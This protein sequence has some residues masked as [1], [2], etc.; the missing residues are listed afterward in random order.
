MKLFSKTAFVLGMLLVGYLPASNA[1]WEAINDN[2]KIGQGKRTYNK[3]EKTLG[4]VVKIKNESNNQYIEPLRLVISQSSHN[5]INQDGITES[6]L[7]Y[8]LLEG[9]ILPRKKLHT[10][11]E[12]SYTPSKLFFDGYLEQY[13]EDPEP[14]DITPP[15]ITLVGDAEFAHEQGTLFVDP[16]ATAIDDKDGS[17][18]VV[19]DG[20]VEEVAGSYTLVY[21]ASDVAGNSASVSRLV[22]VADTLSPVITLL[23]DREITLAYEQSYVELGATALDLV[24]GDV[25]VDISGEVLAEPGEYTITYTA[26]DLAGNSA[27]E[28]RLVTVLEAPVF[29]L[30]VLRGGEVGQEWDRK[31][32]AFDAA[33]GYAECNEDGGA[34]CPS[35]SWEWV[36]DT[37]RGNVLQISHADNNQLAGFFIGSSDAVDLSA[38]ETG[39]LKFDVQVVSGDSNITFKLDCFYPC[40]SGDY[41]IGEKGKDGW[42]T[43][44]IDV[45][46]L[47]NRGLNLQQVN[48]GIVIWASQFTNTVFKLD[49]IHFIG[50]SDVPPP[51]PP[52][53]FEYQISNY[54]LGTISNA[55]NPNSYRCVVDYGNW[56]YN[57]GVV[58]PAIDACDALTGI[59]TGTPKKRYPQVIGDAA[60]KPTP[61]HKWWGSVS[62]LGEMTI[63]DPNDGA[64]ITPDPIT[65]RITDRGFR[66]MGIPAGL[67]T[68]GNSFGY[69]IPDPFSEVFDGLAI[70]NSIHSDLNAYVSDSSDASVTIQWLNSDELVVMQATF[71]HGSSYVYLKAFDGDFVIKSLRADGGEKGVYFQKDNHLGIW[72]NVAGNHNNFLISGEGT[73]VFENI[74]SNSIGVINE[75][76][77]ITV[78]WLPV[79]NATP[80]EAQI[81]AF[82]TLAR[83]VVNRVEIDYAVDRRDNSVTVTHRYFDANSQ[84]ISTLV[85]LQ[86]LHWKNANLATQ[87]PVRSA[88]GITKYAQVSEFSYKLPYVGVLPSLPT[89]SDSL[90]EQT[91]VTLLDEFFTIE[92]AMWNT[93]TDAYW[94][95]KNY[96]KVAELIALADQ[97]GLQL[98][99]NEMRNWLKAEL[100]DWFTAE[101]NDALDEVKYFVYDNDWNTLLALE[102]SFSSHQQ[103]N[104]H[105]FHYG[106]FIRAAAEICRV[107]K[108]WC[109][110][111]QFGPIIEL[112]IRDFAAGK[113]DE[114]FPYVRNFDPANGFSWAS[115]SVN[116]V[117]GNNNESTSEAANA[118]G[119]IVLY[120]LITQNEELVERGMYLHASTSAAY[121]EYW[122]NID[123][124]AQMNDEANNFPNDY[125]YITTSI[126]W[127]DGAVFSTWFSA[128]YAH[129]LGIQGLPTNPLIMH[130]GL[131]KDYM[132]N[133]VDLGLSESA[134]NLPSGLIPGQWRDIWWNLM[135]M[136]DASSAIDDYNSVDSYEPEVGETKAH[137]YHWI[138]TLNSLGQIATGTGALT[139][140]LPSAMAF[141][142]AG[143]ITYVIYNY[144]DTPVTVSFSDGTAV[145]AN[146]NQFTVLK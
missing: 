69:Q 83:N 125:P 138:H 93:R 146:P 85:G 109:S 72:T 81:N 145:I 45:A 15:V 57:A 12:F 2:I 86:P 36:Y 68:S 51:P 63:G 127:G 101:T 1:A 33:I 132:N 111:D 108:A 117:R 76:K 55:I 75:A 62:F 98:Q 48:T 25:T 140:D 79:L 136:T 116:F 31:L 94:S 131:Y 107:D 41:P 50:N 144:N 70:A 134:N 89:L 66:M 73:T 104:D 35:I 20:T 129:I 106:Y 21:S 30:I 84:P 54:G 126:I 64:Y 52:V 92:K 56:I 120:G 9:V 5:V 34:G 137:T 4:V 119:S 24:D 105:H 143:V 99:A 130:V 74:S 115:G 80:T 67:R 90:D 114:M 18:D 124:F 37:E 23:G 19:V 22:T 61:T 39:Q 112:L 118:Y 32:N 16:G 123:G 49:N 8:I 27:T 44:T 96:G 122:N 10:F 38:F 7:P 110:A 11:L 13:I 139:A 29:E 46:D 103:L 91:F 121:W 65:A 28:T 82:A 78:S 95:G 97:A 26:S 53:D 14:E 17:V 141:N 71:V 58:E 43:V 113:N 77:E 40:T 100:Q 102:E 87:Y 6:G 60:T 128:A 42:E 47:K 133:Y 142:N 88:R 3:S 59:P 135:A